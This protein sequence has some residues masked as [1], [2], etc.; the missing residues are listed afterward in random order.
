MVASIRDDITGGL[1]DLL[2]GLFDG[3]LALDVGGRDEDMNH[4]DVAVDARIHIG[5]D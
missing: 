4:I 1:E 3:V 5:P 2:A